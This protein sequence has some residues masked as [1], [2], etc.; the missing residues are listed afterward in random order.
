MKAKNYLAIAFALVLFS[1]SCD[2]LI[3]RDISSELVNIIAPGDGIEV[4]SGRVTFFWD[5][6]EDA[7]E[8]SLQVVTGNFDTPD[9]L[10]LDTFLI[11]NKIKLN[12]DSGTY[13]WGVSSL[14][15]NYQTRYSVRSLTVKSEN[16]TEGEISLIFPENNQVLT[17]TVFQFNWTTESTVSEFVFRVIDDAELSAV[18][19]NS[20]ILVSFPNEN[21]NYQWQVVGLLDENNVTIESPV[22]SFS[23]NPN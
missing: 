3:E 5:H 12:L 17:D 1:L 6:I 7:S 14:N 21:A 10:V 2:E 13:E 11:D 15:T 9:L 18:T 22:Y 8:Y 16:T 4:D 19:S 23:I 20:F